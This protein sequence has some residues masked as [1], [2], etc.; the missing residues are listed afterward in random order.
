MADLLQQMAKEFGVSP[1]RL[2]AIRSEAEK[3]PVR[4]DKKAAARSR[5]AAAARLKKRRKARLAKAGSIAPRNKSNSKK[6]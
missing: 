2:A 6:R 4:V 5:A 3:S 1:K